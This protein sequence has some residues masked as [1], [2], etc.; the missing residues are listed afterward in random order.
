MDK[1]LQLKTQETKQQ[2]STKCYNY[3]FPVYWSLLIF[4]LFVCASSLLVNHKAYSCPSFVINVAKQ[5]FIFFKFFLY[6]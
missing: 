1:S 5:G 3:F 4:F 6:N 2:D